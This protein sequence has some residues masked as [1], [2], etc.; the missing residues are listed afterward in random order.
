MPKPRYVN[1]VDEL[2]DQ[3][4]PWE[5]ATY[6]GYA[7]PEGKT[8]GNVR[9]PCLFNDSCNQSSYGALSVNVDRVHTPIYCHTCGT[10]GKIIELMWGMKHGRPFTGDQLRGAEFKEILTDLQAIRN[11]EFPPTPPLN[12]QSVPSLAGKQPTAANAEQDEP[13]PLV[14][15]PLKDQEKTKGLVNLWEDLITDPGEMPPAA[16]AYFRKRPWL[17]PEVCRKWKMGYLP[18]NG[19]SLMRGL[20]VYAHQNVAGDIISYSGRDAAFEEKWQ[21]WVRDGRPEKKRPNKHRYV[22]GFH[23]GIELYGEI[24]ERLQDRKLKESLG[25]H[26]L[27]VVEGQNDVMRLDCLG[28]AAVGL[29]SNKATDTQIDIIEQISRQASQGK[30]T[31]MPDLDEEGE[32]GFKEL[33]WQ[34]VSRK[35]AVKLGWSSQVSDGKFAGMQPE[36]LNSDDTEELF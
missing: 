30:I 4:R 13:E 22:K 11:R 14:N 1:N 23:K 7:W 2:I 5:A 27:I 9:L 3:T 16:A 25:K 31:L 10:R 15:I 32:A 18:R 19:R 8:S 29:C 35:I 36:Y 20:I 6:Y 33:L 34:L 28:I 21:Q 24:A 12:Q 26:G 17:T